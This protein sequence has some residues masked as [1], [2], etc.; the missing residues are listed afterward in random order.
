[1]RKYLFWAGIIG[2]SALMNAQ[3]TMNEWHDM[4]VNELNR[5][6]LHTEFFAYENETLA[7]QGDK[8]ASNR[9]LSID[10]Q[11]KFLWKE[12]ANEQ[13]KD[14]FR[15]DYDDSQWQNMTVPSIWE[16]NGF[17]DPVYLNIGFAWRGHFTNNPPEVPVRNNHVGSYRRTVTIPSHWDGKQII[18]H[19]G[20]VTSCIYLWVNGQFVGYAEDSKVV[21]EFDITPYLHKG[22]NLL[23]FQVFR[24]SDGS[25]C[26][27]QDCWRLSGV[28]RSCYLYARPQKAHITDIR[29]DTDL[30][31][32]YRDGLLH[33]TTDMKGNGIVTYQL[34]DQEGNTVSRNDVAR[35]K[36]VHRWTAE[37][38]YLYTLL[39][40]LKD[41]KGETL[42]CI[43]IKIG[44]RKVEIKDSQLLVNGQPIYIKGVNRHEIDPDG[45]Y[46]VSRERMIQDIQLMK[47]YNINAVRTS[48]YPNDPLWYDLCDQYGLYVCAEANQESHGFWYKDDSEAKKTIF[49]RQIL[50]RNQ[51][52]VCLNRNH[53]SIIIWSLGNETVDGPN[54]TAAYQWIKSVDKSRPIQFEQAKKGI[55]TD[56]FCPMYLSQGGCEYYAQSTAAEDDKP[57]ILCEYAHAMGNSMGGFKEYWDLVRR[58]PKF[59]GGFIWDFAD[60]GLRSKDAQGK[61]VFR[62]GGDYNDDDPS[63]NNFNCNGLFNP[64]R[65]PNPHAHEVKYYYQNIWSIPVSMEKGI[66]RVKNEYFFRSLTKCQLQWTLLADGIAVQQGVQPLPS[67]E[68]QKEAE[69]QLPY[70]LHEIDNEKEL[71]LNLDFIQTTGDSLLPAGSCIAQEQFIVRKAKSF[72]TYLPAITTQ[73]SKTSLKEDKTSITISNKKICVTFDKNT[74]FLKR[75]EVSGISLLGENGTLKPNFWR[76]VTDNDMG[77]ELQKTNK[78]WRQPTMT[79]T[80]IAAKR[81]EKFIM[82][83][84]QFDMPQ[85]QAT[86][87]IDYTVMPDGTL[88]ISQNLSTTP[89]AKIAELPRFGITMQLPTTMQYSRYYGRGPVEN[90]ADRKGSQRIGIYQQTADEQFYPYIRPQETGTKGDM[91]WWQQTNA[92]GTGLTI[93]A[94]TVFYAGALPYD[95]EELDEGETKQQRHPTELHRSAF[96][97][98]YIDAVHAGLG[99]IDSWTRQGQALGNYRLKYKDYSLHCTIKP[100][101][102]KSSSPYSQL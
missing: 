63:D 29:I 55:N 23:A 86:L 2:F 88:S 68:P 84:S 72:A 27:D 6:P 22:Q 85:V 33:V 48:H 4:Q 76:A 74:G 14:F 36:D 39:T 62:Y 12:H 99:G 73:K 3:P 100:I 24:W 44:F 26:E 17:G 98:L 69:I 31:N 10:G 42:E 54:F 49:A 37:T 65:Q 46:V 18:A 79:L 96:V 67:V 43:P 28:G 1:M 75:Y 9:Y 64:D 20:A 25:Y 32:D 51:H 11:W 50:E 47:Q 13:P 83:S 66:I 78:V 91:R 19:F 89:N 87:I 41:S 94:D 90:Y 82:V 61:E 92:D 81:N 16:L 102:E 77:A 93:V 40:T 45:G 53:P 70:S 59:Q 80:S 60:Q 57:L 35:L 15:T 38:P 5:L 56:I 95:I 21:A 34:K 97:N 30:E 101:Q 52:N 71:L 58:Y 8:T 7:Q